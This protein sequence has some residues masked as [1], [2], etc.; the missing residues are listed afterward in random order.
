MKIAQL[1]TGYS[2]AQVT[3]SIE[4]RSMQSRYYQGQDLSSGLL[5]RQA[6][7]I[8]L[9]ENWELVES[10]DLYNWNERRLRNL[11]ARNQ[12]IPAMFAFANEA[13]LITRLGPR[14]IEPQVGSTLAAGSLPRLKP[15]CSPYSKCEAF[16]VNCSTPLKVSR[17]APTRC[18]RIRHPHWFS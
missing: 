8:G 15:M 3:R 13:L 16:Q 10:R 18:G 12:P 17:L 1:T 2:M 7:V 6:S 5:P 11:P 9:T 14:Q 4:R